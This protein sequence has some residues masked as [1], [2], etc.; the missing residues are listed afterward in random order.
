MEVYLL[1][2]LHIKK[3][4]CEDVKI[5]G[6]YSTREKALSAVEWAKLQPG[7]CDHPDIIDPFMDEN[8]EGFYID[9]YPLNKDC[10]VDGFKEL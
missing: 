6:I 10:W 4:A 9:K 7:F 3:N 8:T 1:Q 2:H 5:I